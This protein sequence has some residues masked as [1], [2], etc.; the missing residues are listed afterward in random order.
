M[1]RFRRRRSAEPRCNVCGGTS[2]TDVGVRAAVRCAECGSLERTRLM[3]LVIDDRSLVTAATRVLHIAP[4][5]GLARSFIAAG[6]DCRFVDLD[7]AGF[8]DLAGVERLDLCRD[9]DALDDRSFD[10][11][12]HSHVLEHVPCNYTYVLFH[13]HRLLADEGAIVCCIPFLPGHYG[14]DTSPDVTADQ[15]NERYGQWDHVRRFGTEDL[16]LSLGRVYDLPATYDARDLVD[17][18][19][20][21]AANVPLHAWTGF[22]PHSVL[23]FARG[24]Y[25]LT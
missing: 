21:V 3:K 10:L 11:V 19:S 1:P 4:E 6:A 5:P 17:E 25:R 15:R 2:F 13:L 22:T 12:V 16:D 9:L 7:P 24:D 14:S 23:V 8:P 18:A 20:L